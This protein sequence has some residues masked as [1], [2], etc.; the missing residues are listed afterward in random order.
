MAPEAESTE[1]G[2]S[3][4]YSEEE[5]EEEYEIEYMEDKGRLPGIKEE[6]SEDSGET[7]SW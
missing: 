6:F 5:V 4:E 3:S 2:F 7:G 1:E